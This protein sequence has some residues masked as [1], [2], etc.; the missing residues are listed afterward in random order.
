M[1]ALHGV[2]PKRYCRIQTTGCRVPLALLAGLASR[3]SVML[4]RLLECQYQLI[5]KWLLRGTRVHQ[6]CPG[7]KPAAEI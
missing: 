3:D 6:S 4:G 5:G 2:V 7:P 1:S